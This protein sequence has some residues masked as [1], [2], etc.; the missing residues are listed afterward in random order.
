MLTKVPVPGLN[1]RL[2]TYAKLKYINKKIISA[3]V[4]KLIQGNLY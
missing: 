3:T 4:E 1:I 2:S